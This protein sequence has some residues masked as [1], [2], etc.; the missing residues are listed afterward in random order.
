MRR[1]AALTVAALAL[2]ACSDGGP[3]ADTTTAGTEAVD[4]TAATSTTAAATTT[5]EPPSTYAATIDELLALDRPIVLAHTAGEDEFPASTLY[6]FGESVKAGVDMLDLNI[7]LT[8]DNELLVQHDDTF[9]RNTDGTGAVVDLTAAEAW[10]LDAAYWFTQ[11]CADCRDRAEADYLW[12]GIRTGEKEPP[13]GYTADDFALP[14]LR[15]LVERFPDIPLNIEIKGE[16]DIALRTAD[17]LAAQLK[18]LGRADAS[19]VASFS[20]DVVAYYH[21]ID[22]DTEVSPG[23]NVLTGWVL[24]RAPIPDG[25]RILQLPPEFSG[26]QVIT[27]LLVADSTAAG[28]PIWVWPNDRDLENLESYRDFLRQGIVGLNI[29]FPAQ[30]VQ[31]VDEFVAANDVQA[32]ASAGCDT[33]TPLA[34]GE[35]TEALTAAGLD[36][37][38]VQHLPPAYD[39][40]T[41]LPLVLGLHGWS[42]PAALLGQQSQL[43]AMGDRHR[44]VTLLPD[45]T[46][47]V[48]LWD[49]ALDSADVEWITALLDQV[50]TTLCIDTNRVYVAG[51]SNGAMMTSTLA[52]VLSDRVAAVAPVA[53]VRDPE[54]CEPER[55]VPMIAFHGTDD[56]YLAYEGGYGPKV[57]ALPNPDG[58]GTLGDSFI[59]G[60]SDAEPVPDRV[61]AWADRNGCLA[62]PTE[63]PVADDIRLLSSIDCVEG[64]TLLYTVV[65]GGHSWPGSAFDM[66]IPDLVGPT[67]ATIDA[68]ALMSLFFGRYALTP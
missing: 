22:P 40:A 62:A 57:A 16:G 39:G 42:Q 58:T 47:P 45:I 56:E 64:A 35:T 29:N 3:T 12:R 32:A 50:G 66:A 33:E 61:T 14:T 65:G 26:L 68:T 11:D 18:E 60:G 10:E 30:G 19:V 13:S 51:M 48:P 2:A 67:T 6:G 44:F 52:C 5:T 24:E 43:P 27:P 7:N 25:M 54:G 9:D 15:Q 21:S 49:T 63:E 1:L 46:R 4:T 23:L 31:A 41:P 20:D 8:K 53:G 55:P 36:G 17:V 28:F 38:Y 59:A 37:T 34:A